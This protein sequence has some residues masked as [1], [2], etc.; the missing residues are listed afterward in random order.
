MLVPRHFYLLVPGGKGA[1]VAPKENFEGSLWYG[2]RRQRQQNWVGQT[3]K[4]EPKL[5]WR[6]LGLSDRLVHKA[7][8]SVSC[9]SRGAWRSTHNFLP[10]L[11]SCFSVSSCKEAKCTLVSGE[12]HD[13]VDC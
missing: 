12:T 3:T 10:S 7:L 6:G 11:L 2:L 8:D 13:L 1:L 5:P 9:T 4:G